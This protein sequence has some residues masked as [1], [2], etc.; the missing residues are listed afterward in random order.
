MAAACEERPLKE[1]AALWMK[2]GCETGPVDKNRGGRGAKGK[3]GLE[4]ESERA[5]ERERGRE[6]DLPLLHI[7]V[8]FS[9]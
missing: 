9:M 3:G 8:S 7:P 6:R 5:S 4:R 1:T 2:T